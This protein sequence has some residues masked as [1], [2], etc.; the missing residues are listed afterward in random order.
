MSPPQVFQTPSARDTL[1]ADLDRRDVA[2]WIHGRPD[3][4]ST[5]L[6]LL[7]LIALPWNLVLS[8]VSDAP[9]CAALNASADPDDP[10]ARKRGFIHVVRSSPTEV[11]LPPQC[12]PVYLLP[13]RGDGDFEA[14]LTRLAMLDQL[15]RSNVRQLLVVS[16]P[17]TP[18]PDELTRIWSAGFRAALTFFA[19]SPNAASALSDWV[20]SLLSPTPVTLLTCPPVEL[21]RNLPSTFSTTYPEDRLL[22]RIRDRAGQV[23]RL[24]LTTSDDPERSILSNFELVKERDV[25]AITPDQLPEVDFVS[26]FQNATSSWRPYAAGLPWIRD[27][28]ARQR[29]LGLLAKLDLGGPDE[30]SIAYLTAESGSGGTTF[31]RNLARE[32]ALA[33]YPVLVAKNFPFEPNAASLG[34]FLKRLH[35]ASTSGCH[36]SSPATPETTPPG[37]A[38]HPANDSVL[39]EVPTL[40]VF[41]RV[42][43]E[44]RGHELRRF[45][46]QLMRQGRPVCL[47]VVAGPQLELTYLDDSTFHRIAHLNH[48]L[49]K[50]EA[51]AL[52][53]HL[54]IYLRAYGKAR[55]AWEWENF[56][57]AHTLNYLDGIAAFWVTLSFWIQREYDLS[58]S[59]QEWMYRRF[60]SGVQDFTLRLAVLEIAAM[61]ASRLPMPDGILETPSGE[62]PIAH[63][64]DDIRPLLGP[65]GLSRISTHDVKYWALI[66]DI[67]G[68]FLLTAL[69]Y[70]YKMRDGLG[71]AAA[72]DP[73]HLR[74]LLLKGVSSRIRL[75]ERRNRPTADA[76]ATTLFKID[77]DHASGHFALFWREVFDALDKM[78][79]ALQDSSRVFR[80]HTAISRRRVSKLDTAVYGLSEN[81]RVQL[82]ERA[83]SD[84]EY[85]LKSIEYEEG[86]EA[87]INLYNSLAHAYHDLADV[88][89]S[90]NAAD[91]VVIELRRR[92]SAATRRAYEAN[93]TSSFVVEI[94]VRDLLAIADATPAMAIRCCVEAMGILL[95]AL[96]SSARNYRRAQL[97]TLAEKALAVLLKRTP[98]T[99]IERAPANPIDVLTKAWIAL[100]QGVDYRDPAALS[101]IPKENRIA[102][103]E[104]LNHRS[105]RGNLLVI[106][107]AYD[108]VC[109]VKPLEYELQLEYLE[110]LVHTEYRF[111]AQMK[112]EYGILLF[113]RNRPVEADSVFRE[114]RRQWRE[115][116]QFV[117]VPGRLRW[118][119]DSVTRKART[120]HAVVVSGGA[121]RGLAQV[122]EFRRLRVPFRPEEFAAP[123]IRAGATLVGKVSFGPNGPFLRPVTARVQ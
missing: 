112:L 9:L 85:A 33:G 62:W 5:P 87:D 28:S 64:L 36:A 49:S 13:D 74:F 115:N 111:H 77:P 76:F 67:L 60:L 80:H 38:E 44:A 89:A 37:D 30:N 11:E 82:L 16:S 18:V 104:I 110:Q 2:L 15:R 19:D 119:R 48:E 70:D 83:I 118:L 90:R 22:I 105:G 117:D 29:V 79:R 24:D 50:D 103:L 25:T 84:I 123:S 71:F 65:L 41:D 6:D 75:A 8:D 23:R 1:L 97:G 78:P 68:R 47:L 54:N 32:V 26:F 3:T 20:K 56:H 96:A 121:P 17:A 94:Y 109:S 81:D 91:A 106:R 51:L 95:S 7:S 14:Q 102:A 108:L 93:P 59:I 86:S 122:S 116:D 52:G 31:V 53:R 35:I 107:L 21:L 43:W 99:V 40:L 55:E 42:H 63:R 113:Q 66:H 61:S 27:S 69:F 92:A 88:E 100:A 98:Q 46:R 10:L 73:E 120:V 72:K 114:L 45:R 101:A 12:L 57:K 39:Y 58:E 34:A 4:V